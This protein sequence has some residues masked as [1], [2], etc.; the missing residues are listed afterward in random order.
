MS[1]L[2]GFKGHACAP[3]RTQ[4][5]CRSYVLCIETPRTSARESFLL[6]LLFS[7][8]F[9]TTLLHSLS[10]SSS[11]LLFF[12]AALVF[13]SCILHTPPLT[14]HSSSPFIYLFVF[15]SV[16]GPLACF[17]TSSNAPCMTLFFSLAAL[18]SSSAALSATLWRSPRPPST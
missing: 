14:T 12:F 3:L 18:S 5:L 8:H 9:Q 10:L 1:A 4:L 17:L 11:L 16:F 13:D 2:F 7:F 6:Q 15:I